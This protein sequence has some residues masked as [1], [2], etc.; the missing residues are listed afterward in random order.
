M[1]KLSVIIITLNE[2]ANLDRCLRSLQGIADEVIVVDS[3]SA[4][5]TEEIALQYGAVFLQR[6]FSGYG[7][8]KAAGLAKAKHDLLLVI[9]ADEAL[10]EELKQSM[11]S[12]KNQ[13]TADAYELKRLTNY[14]GKW[15]RHGG[16]YPDLV[17]RLWKKGKAFQ[18]ED[19]L[20]E[21][22]VANEGSV[23][24]KLDGDLLHYSFPTLSSHL[25]KVE[26]YSESGARYDV[27]R[28]KKVSLL[29]L[30]FGPIWVFLNSWI[31]KGGFLDGYYGYLIAKISAFAAFLKYAKIR[32]YTR[33]P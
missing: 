16:W 9:D 1:H 8:Q 25:R 21:K 2:S 18:N 23:V 4:D 27:E 28:G 6:K 10:S 7:S 17:M 22:I 29:K 30:L 31:F 24:A 26:Q 3:Y 11:H 20:H 32:E 14:C 19:A 13:P 12:I 33:R 15:I 5:D